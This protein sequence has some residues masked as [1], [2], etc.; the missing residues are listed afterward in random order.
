ME[1][2]LLTLVEIQDSPFKKLTVTVQIN[3]KLSL[4][5]LKKSCA[6]LKADNCNE[7]NQSR[8]PQLGAKK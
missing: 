6:D 1:I 8:S 5:Y 2:F 4:T 7:R 3:N